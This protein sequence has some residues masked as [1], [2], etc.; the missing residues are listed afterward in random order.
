MSMD[1]ALAMMADMNKID[2]ALGLIVGLCALR[3]FWRGFSRE[4]FGVVGVVAG[5]WVAFRLTPEGAAFLRE[6]VEAPAAMLDGTAF[7]LLFVVANAATA[8]VAVLFGRKRG[9]GLRRGVAGVGGAVVGAG[10]GAVVLSF[11]LLFLQLFP[12]VPALSTE[13]MESAIGR[14]LV[15]VAGGLLRAMHTEPSAFAESV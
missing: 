5:I 4:C 8:I 2:A 9:T 1:A 10:K 13:I 3:G 11:L 7:V 15:R 14:P 6:H 12:V